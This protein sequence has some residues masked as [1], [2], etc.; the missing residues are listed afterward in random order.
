MNL[1]IVYLILPVI[2]ALIG[3]ITNYIAVKM[4]FRP[5]KPIH[6]FGI[7]L[8]G[9]IPKRKSD[10][11]KK[12]GETVEHELISHQDIHEVVNTPQFHEEILSSVMR[13]IDSFIEQKLGANPIVSMI[14]SG[15]VAMQIKKLVKNELR[16][17]LPDFMEDIFEKVEHRLDFK[18]IVQ[19]KIEQFDMAKLETIVYNIA[20]KELRAIEVFG[21]VLGFGV[22]LIQVAILILAGNTHG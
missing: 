22:G 8:W 4:I 12:I 7:T 21:G 15:D 17:I 14:L 19:H 9:L 20:A 6:F 10:L 13:A 1:P 3:W 2:S 18:E 11:A 16:T 5:R